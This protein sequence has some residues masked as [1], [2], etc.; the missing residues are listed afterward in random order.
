MSAN[1]YSRPRFARLLPTMNTGQTPNSAR[2]LPALFLSHGAPTLLLDDGPT[3][4]FLRSLGRSLERPQ[5]IVVVSAHWE[6]SE[7]R[8]L[9]APRPT[10][11]YD[12]YGFPAPLYEMTYPA[13][14]A[15]ELAA[16][17]Q[18]LLSAAG[19]SSTLDRD[20]GYDHGVWVPLKLMFPNA[21]IPVT[22]VSI[23]PEKPPLYHWRLGRALS[24]LRNQ[25][26][27]V[28]GSGS[29]THNL[30]DFRVHRAHADAPALPYVSEFSNWIDEALALQ[31]LDRLLAYRTTA[32]HAMQAHPTDEHL[33]PLFVALGAA[34]VS[35]HALRVHHGILHGAIAMN[36]YLFQSSS[37]PVPESA[38][39]TPVH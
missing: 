13:P 16:S 8:V 36:A 20:R 24:P 2:P 7:P 1:S 21:D 35:W 14:G 5:A 28:L 3:T 30:A 10:T 19:F 4:S 9:G 26:V 25:G 6:A 11:L 39:P 32:P 33:M 29:L 37:G 12:F 22:Q 38:F 31:S 18:E 23:N 34:G 27:L 15:I 17:V